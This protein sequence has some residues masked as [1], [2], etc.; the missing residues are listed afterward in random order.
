V[1]LS[2]IFPAAVRVGDSSERGGDDGGWVG[3]HQ[4]FI[5]NARSGV[6]H[7]FIAVVSVV[8]TRQPA[9][10][11]EKRKGF[12]FFLPI[13]VSQ[14]DKSASFSDSK[15]RRRG[16]IRPARGTHQHERSCS[17]RLGRLFIRMDEPALNVCSLLDAALGKSV[18]F[19]LE[20][21]LLPRSQIDLYCE[22]PLLK[23]H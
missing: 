21:L 10:E 7:Q 16:D 6:G 2:R 15:D 19:Q 9:N 13:F 14:I 12:S 20:S 8:S 18:P 11:R 1:L 5:F 23:K 22:I 4:I 3:V 17:E